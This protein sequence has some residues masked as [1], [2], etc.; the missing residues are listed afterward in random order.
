M[1]NNIQFSVN[2]RF[3][4]TANCELTNR[5]FP[6]CC[7]P[8]YESEAKCKAFHTKVIFVCIWVKTNFHNKNF[9][10]SLAFIMRFKATR[11]WPIRWCCCSNAGN[12][13]RKLPIFTEQI[14]WLYV[15]T[16]HVGPCVRC[17]PL[18]LSFWS[19]FSSCDGD[20]VLPPC[21]SSGGVKLTSSPGW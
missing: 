14:I 12:E 3:P 6:S 1:M 7:E 8:H 17:V 16:G 5:P 20:P 18:Y 13:Q 2:H 15:S 9:A 10:F 19:V 4:P 11:K 21:K